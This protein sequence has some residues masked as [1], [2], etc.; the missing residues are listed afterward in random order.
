MEYY[1]DKS[2]G[3]IG[4]GEGTIIRSGD[5]YY[6]IIEAPDVS[7]SCQFQYEAQNWVVGLLRSPSLYYESGKWEQVDANPVFVPWR[8]W[9]CGIQYHRFFY[10]QD[11]T[12]VTMWIYDWKA[13]TAILKFWIIVP[14]EGQFPYKV[15]NP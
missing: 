5:Y 11:N 7:L 12:Y 3:C 2:T 4:G 8:K 15:S 14:G 13:M 9:G 10:Y 1:M 6:Q